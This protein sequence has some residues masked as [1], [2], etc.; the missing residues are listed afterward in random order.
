MNSSL[1][2]RLQFIA[3]LCPADQV[4]LAGDEQQLSY[5][6]L[7]ESSEA[8]AQWLLSRDCKVVALHADNSIDWV[9]VDLACQM[10]G[11]ICIPVPNFFSPT[12][13]EHSL[14]AA[15]ADWLLTAYSPPPQLI[16]DG[17]P[18]SVP[19]IQLSAWRL[20]R[21]DTAR[22]IPRGTHKITFTSGS[23]GA[24]KG[25]CLSSAHQWQVAE[26]LAQLIAIDNPR[27]LC[28]LPLATLLENIAGIYTP[29]LCGGTILLP[30]AAQRGMDGSSGLQL[31][32]LLRCLHDSQ[33]HSMVLLPQLLIA[34]VA[35]C[36]QGWV[37]PSSLK[38]IAVGGARVAPELILAARNSGLPVYEG[39]GLSECG[40]VVA[41][42]T[43]AN[44]CPGS[45]GRV[46]PHCQVA[47]DDGEI[48]ITG[49]SH[50]GYLGDPDSW[51]PASIRSGDLGAL[52]EFGQLH[53]NGRRKN[54]LITSF[55]RNVSPE[56]VESELLG[57]ALLTRC[58]VLGDDRPYLVA[59][60]TAPESQGNAAIDEC[61]AAVNLRLPDYARIGAWHRLQADDWQGM[62]TANGR[63]RR[64]VIA[65][66]FTDVIQQLYAAEN[67]PTSMVV[68]EK[69][70]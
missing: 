47:I 52:N 22:L 11:V 15:G 34:L 57:Q 35:A 28:L 5:G 10:A 49:S 44:D 53:V 59:L 58:V 66:E 45:V 1:I 19:S 48:V 29:L 42:N 55:G 2:E 23:T 25:V 14:N 24:P 41:L 18:I 69:V 8:L 46:L 50:L 63:P 43:P 20:R 40:S 12:Q 65:R 37:P 26:S 36:Q 13:M 16:L 38:Y 9:L 32:V 7:C 64:D 4:A 30:A 51:S 68:Q 31:D 56:W 60:L 61:I 27:H 62:L 39:Y 17:Q 67:L 21:D 54:V 70:V 3:Q 33:P 6:Q